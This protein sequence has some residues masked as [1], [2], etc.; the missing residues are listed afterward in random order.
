MLFNSYGFIFGFLPVVLA[1]FYL[2]GQ[3]RQEWALL[4]L[5]GA[6][7]LFYAAWRPLNVVLIA[8]SILINFAIAWLLQRIRQDRKVL[9]RGVL[10]G[11]ILFNVCFLGYFKYLT[12]AQQ[13]LNDVLGAGFVLTEIIMPLGL[14]FITFQKIAFLVDVHAGRVSRVSF[15]EYT[16]FVTFFPQLIAGPIVHYREVMPQFNAA[17]CRYD[18]DTVAVGLTLFFFGLA[19]KLVLADPLGQIVAPVYARAAVGVPQTLTEAWIAALGFTLQ[20]YFDFSG[21]CDMALGLARFFGIRLPVNFNSPFKATSIIDFWARWH[22]TLTRFLT[23]Y[24]YMPMTLGLT[25][26][27]VAQGK[28]IRGGAGLGLPAFLTLL[29]MPTMLTMLVS[30]LW[31][32][33][34]YT[35]ILWGLLHGMLLVVNHGWRMIRPLIWRHTATYNRVAGPAGWLLTFVSVVFTM[36]MFRSPTVGTAVMLWKG[37]A[38]AYGATLPQVVLSRLGVFGGWLRWIGFQPAWSSG[39]LLLIATMHIA[40][41]LFIAL[42]MPNTLEL[43]AAYEPALGVKPAK[44]RGRL[45]RWAAWQ[46]NQAWAAGLACV[47][48]AGILS[49]G[50]LHAF[51]YW[52]F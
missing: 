22:V 46:P 18:A 16:L 49:L 4:W 38:G 6:S 35:F 41:L 33:A 7:L 24:L 44:A 19:K 42:A 28:P 31:H 37:M 43:L 17:S 30:G 36:A 52:Q 51:I 5:T 12:F 11:G 3:R 40:V 20:I 27:R 50:G 14:S 10:I 8:P 29:A 34:G 9:A 21:Y 48:M 13:A 1:G 25:R 45:L 26:R 2:I 47:A 15:P 23:A 32:G 39:S